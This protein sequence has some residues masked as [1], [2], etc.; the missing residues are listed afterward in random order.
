MA[1]L[2]DIYPRKL[3]LGRVAERTVWVLGRQPLIIFGVALVLYGL[4]TAGSMELANRWFSDSLDLSQ[5][6]HS[7]AIGG[8]GLAGL[9]IAALLEGCL[10]ATAFG[11]LGGRPATLPEVLTTGLKFLLP[12]FAVN[13][14]FV[15]AFVAGLILLIVPGVML[16]LAWCV[17]GPALLV[18][19]SGI[20]TVFGRSADLTRDNRW[21]LF[22]LA[23][24]FAVASSIIQSGPGY[25]HYVGSP[26]WFDDMVFSPISIL[27][28]SVLSSLFHAVAIVALAVIY[29]ELRTLKEGAP[30]AD[31]DQVFS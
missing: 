29:V 5:F 2:D 31:L 26:F 21:R 20:T 14:F 4:P 12:L 28:R 24:I 23:L 10:L 6:F 25:H 3:D 11:E 18:E 9:L 19:R 8:T 16:A 15:L 13:L 7:P 17:A 27:V 1:A 22:G 30:P